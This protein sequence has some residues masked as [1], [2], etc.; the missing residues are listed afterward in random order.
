ML[1]LKLPRAGEAGQGFNVV[2]DQVRKLANESRKAVDN[3]NEILKDIPLI[4]QTQETN[5]LNVLK[6]IEF[7]RIH[8]GRNFF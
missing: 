6:S 3:T 2:A 8:C 7:N 1:R 4:T 5:A